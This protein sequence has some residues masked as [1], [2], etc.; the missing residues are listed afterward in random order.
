MR[1]GPLTNQPQTPMTF[2]DPVEIPDATPAELATRRFREAA[3]LVRRA[4]RHQD[5]LLRGAVTA[6]DIT[7]LVCPST[8]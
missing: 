4:G 6:P 2:P 8:S 7:P 1:G 5:S 3:K